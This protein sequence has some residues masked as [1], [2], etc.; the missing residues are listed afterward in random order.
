[1]TFANTVPYVN[2]SDFSRVHLESIP[3]A[4]DQSI[5]AAP[6]LQLCFIIVVISIMIPLF[7]MKEPLLYLFFE[8]HAVV[9]MMRL[10]SRRRES[11][12]KGR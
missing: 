5:D 1:M 10:S 8:L 3:V 7:L 12:S 2:I 9:A 6:I 11:S 4:D